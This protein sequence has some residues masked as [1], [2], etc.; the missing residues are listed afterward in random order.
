VQAAVDYGKVA[1]FIH[2]ILNLYDATPDL[3]ELEDT[4]YHL[5]HAVAHLSDCLSR[6]APWAPAPA[7]PI[8][9]HLPHGLAVAMACLRLRS[10][11]TTF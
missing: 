5:P 7:G 3:T 1:Q 8:S 6:S 2:S 9:F 4:T 11:P 10:L